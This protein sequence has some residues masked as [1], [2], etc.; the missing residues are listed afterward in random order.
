M[1]KLRFWCI[2]NDNYDYDPDDNTNAVVVN[3]KDS[4]G[5]TSPK[6]RLELFCQIFFRAEIRPR[7]HLNCAPVYHHFIIIMIV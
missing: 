3:D 2:D 6:V 4:G 1:I 7:G 5:D